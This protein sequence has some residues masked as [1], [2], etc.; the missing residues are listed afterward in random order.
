V[1]RFGLKEFQ[2]YILAFMP[3]SDHL[4]RA[5]GTLDAT[6][7]DAKDALKSARQTG[8]GQMHHKVDVE[9]SIL[10]EPI[11]KTDLD[12]EPTDP[13]NGFENSQAFG[14]DLPVFADY[15]YLVNVTR[16][17]FAWGQRLGRRPGSVASSIEAVE[18]LRPWECLKDEALDVLANATMVEGFSYNEVYSGRILER[19]SG[20]RV[21]VLVGFDVGLLQW[22]ERTD[23]TSGRP[24]RREREPSTS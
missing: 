10:G 4:A 3:H 16:H 21:E 18:D 12:L 2:L 15:L 23:G 20:E 11:Y 8:L 9:I 17:G 24:Q 7:D 5:L 14:F 22:V 1:E 19:W 13:P 6:W